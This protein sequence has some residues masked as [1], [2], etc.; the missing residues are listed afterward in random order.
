MK[1]S[2]SVEYYHL[3]YLRLL[4]ILIFMNTLS[5]KRDQKQHLHLVKS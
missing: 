1:K 3:I 2:C 5:R 4:K